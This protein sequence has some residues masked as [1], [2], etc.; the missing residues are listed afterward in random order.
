MNRFRVDS[1]LLAAS[2]TK[3]CPDSL[4][5]QPQSLFLPFP[6]S[7]YFSLVT[8]A[9]P[10]PVHLPGEQLLMSGFAFPVSLSQ[11]LPKVPKSRL[12]QASRAPGASTA[13]KSAREYPGLQHITRFRPVLKD[14]LR[15]ESGTS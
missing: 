12:Q 9:F 8:I 7:I 11:K 10:R 15:D 4:Y 14:R 6:F 3:R 5:N 2:L 13:V 1:H